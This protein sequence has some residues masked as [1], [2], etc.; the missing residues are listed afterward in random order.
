MWTKQDKICQR[1]GELPCLCLLCGR[2]TALGEK[3]RMVQT[4]EEQVGQQQGVTD[5]AVPQGVELEALGGV[6]RTPIGDLPGFIG[7]MK[8]PDRSYRM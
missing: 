3:Q 4:A 2:G 1:H 6:Q 5:G 7:L 8:S